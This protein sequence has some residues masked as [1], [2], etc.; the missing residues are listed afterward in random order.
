MLAMFNVIAPVFVPPARS[1]TVIPAAYE[2]GA[3][4]PAHVIVFVPDAAQ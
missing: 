2:E 4:D 3:G 1:E